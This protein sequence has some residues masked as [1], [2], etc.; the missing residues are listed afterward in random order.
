MHDSKIIGVLKCLDKKE[1]RAFRRYLESPWFNQHEE[2]LLLFDALMPYAPNFNSK[3]LSK[4]KIFQRLYPGEEFDAARLHHRV[5]ELYKLLERYLVQLEME[6][7]STQQDFL[8][9]RATRKRKLDTH[10]RRTVEGMEK[11]FGRADKRDWSLYL[12]RFL[13]NYYDYTHPE[14]DKLQKTVPSLQRSMD[15]LDLFFA[16]AKLKL[17]CEMRNRQRMLNNKYEINFLDE[18]LR[19]TQT[20]PFQ[21]NPVFG[22]YTQFLQAFLDFGSIRYEELRDLFMGHHDLFSPK[23]R[24]DYFVFLINAYSFAYR[25]GRSDIREEQF[26]LYTMAL[27]LGFLIDNGVLDPQFFNHIVL[28]G[29][30][31]EKYDWTE[32]FIDD[33]CSYLPE[34]DRGNFEHMSYAE[35]YFSAKR[36]DEAGDHLLQVNFKDSPFRMRMRAMEICLDYEYGHFDLLDN[37]LSAFNMFLRRDKSLARPIIERNQHFVKVMRSMARIRCKPPYADVQKDADQLHESISSEESIIFKD[38][39]LEKSTQLSNGR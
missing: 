26:R 19:L 16:A 14:T 25:S 36:Y 4:E 2:R 8:F 33:Y 24:I 9:L 39:L 3:G 22:I 11:S 10:F 38:W 1:L 37:H 28:I 21:D 27:E 29:S 13:V 20:E 12:N 17:A 35:L 30:S 31:L 15:Q 32:A 6:S 5:S 34:K 23:E 7:D 18:V